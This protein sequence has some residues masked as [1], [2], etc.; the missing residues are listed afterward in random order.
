[1][2]RKGERRV[3]GA[4]A[5]LPSRPFEQGV[6]DGSLPRGRR[7]LAFRDASQLRGLPTHAASASCRRPQRAPGPRLRRGARLIPPVGRSIWLSGP[8]W[9]RRDPLEPVLR[10]F[11]AILRSPHG[12][13]PPRRSWP[14]SRC[15]PR[16]RPGVLSVPEA[17]RADRRKSVP[18]RADFLSYGGSRRTVAVPG[19][20]SAGTRRATYWWLAFRT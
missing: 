12:S 14:S 4:H 2:P 8:C 20:T 6:D 5:G 16:P 15:K 3:R 18:R 7:K 19:H 17:C 1:M 10:G 9:R 13:S 11:L